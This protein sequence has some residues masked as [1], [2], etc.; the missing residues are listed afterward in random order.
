M[1]VYDVIGKRSD[2]DDDDNS[3]V[4]VVSRKNGGGKTYVTLEISCKN[5]S[6]VTFFILKPD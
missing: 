6:K 5:R 4:C 1:N 3:G 2:D